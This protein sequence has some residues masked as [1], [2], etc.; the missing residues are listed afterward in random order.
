L[1]KY[2]YQKT[3]DKVSSPMGAVETKHSPLEFFECFEYD[4]L[5]NIIFF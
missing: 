2:F 5:Q 4:T 3:I 1:S